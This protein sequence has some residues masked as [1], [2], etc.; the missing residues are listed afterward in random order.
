MKQRS[1]I[2]C[3][4]NGCAENNMG[5]P[6]RGWPVGP[7][8]PIAK[9]DS[10]PET[11][12]QVFSFIEQGLFQAGFRL[13]LGGESVVQPDSYQHVDP[14]QFG[15]DWLG[16]QEPAL[17]EDAI[18]EHYS[19]GRFKPAG[20]GGQVFSGLQDH[21]AGVSAQQYGVQTRS[22]AKGLQI[23]FQLIQ[24][25]LADQPLQ[26][27]PLRG[28]H[29]QVG[30][31]VQFIGDEDMGGLAPLLADCLGLLLQLILQEEY[32]GDAHCQGGQDDQR[33]H[34]KHDLPREAVLLSPQPVSHA[35]PPLTP[36]SP[37]ISS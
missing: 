15:R 16:C 31:V 37:A 27:G 26:G 28:Q 9:L 17:G 20:L 24:I 35:C 11:G 7:A 22:L 1:P 14:F 13:Q 36:N 6:A 3:P 2:R 18:E 33:Y 4:G 19:G 30:Q 12:G 25:V 8:G 34:W 21:L 29:C 10:H 23:G 5:Q 32:G